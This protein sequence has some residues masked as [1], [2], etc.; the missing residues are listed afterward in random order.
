MDLGLRGKK[1]IITGGSRGIG[2][3][4]AECLADEG[5]DVGF[6]SRDAKQVAEA[7]KSLHTKGIRA[8]GR[9]VDLTDADA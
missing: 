8:I 9:A 6:C 1:V 7:E 5:V 3:A 2:R 4:T